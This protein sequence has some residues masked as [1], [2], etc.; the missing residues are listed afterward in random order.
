MRKWKIF[1]RLCWPDQQVENFHSVVLYDSFLQLS[2]TLSMW[3]LTWWEVS[4]PCAPLKV[5]VCWFSMCPPLP[6]PVS[7]SGVILTC[8]TLASEFLGPKF[9]NPF[10]P[11]IVVLLTPKNTDMHTLSVVIV[12]HTAVYVS[13]CPVCFVQAL[14]EAQ[15]AIQQLFGKIKD[16]KDKAEKSEQ[17]VRTHTCTHTHKGGLSKLNRDT[18]PAQWRYSLYP[19]SV[20]IEDSGESYLKSR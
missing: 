1:S 11:L 16:I 12:Q 10:S 2:S 19:P 15:I 4:H 7:A 18:A 6:A 8:W 17:M 5:L 14:E 20:T 9:P 3:K 13:Y